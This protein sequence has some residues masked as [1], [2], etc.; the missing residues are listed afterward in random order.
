MMKTPKPPTSPLATRVTVEQRERIEQ[1]A[2]DRDITPS[3]LLRKIV[4]KYL[5]EQQKTA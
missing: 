2:N 4:T 3:K 5:D 1:I